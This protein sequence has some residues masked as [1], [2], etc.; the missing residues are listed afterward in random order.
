MII[1]GSD[2]SENDRKFAKANGMGMEILNYSYP[3]FAD[4]FD[5]NNSAVMQSFADVKSLSMHGAFY[6]LYHTSVDPLICDVARQRF[7]QSVDIASRLD[8]NRVVFHSSYRKLFDGSAMVEHFLEKAISFWKDFEQY[9]PEG[10][11]IYLENIEDD[12]PEVFVQIFKGVNSPK[13]R[14]CFDVGHAYMSHSVSLNRW[15]DV[16]CDYIGHVHI[17]DNS[18]K[19]DDHLPLGQG[20]IPIAG[21]I[22]KLL[23][24]VGEYVPF[25]LECDMEA[26]VTWLRNTGFNV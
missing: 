24:T 25:V 4:N 7:I 22:N 11:K 5:N 14:C 12:D 19:N 2:F 26:S 8:I 10:M 23:H 3:L 17:H 20:S 21:A 13:I 6:D 18:G 9:I 16:L 15:I 1:Y